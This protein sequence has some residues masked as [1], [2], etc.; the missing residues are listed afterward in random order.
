MTE[1]AG[2]RQEGVLFSPQGDL[3]PGFLFG[4]SLRSKKPPEVV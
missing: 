3:G 1:L 2:R 4:A